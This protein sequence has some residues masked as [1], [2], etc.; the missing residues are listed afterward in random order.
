MW[1]QVKKPAAP[2]KKSNTSK[3]DWLSRLKSW[4]WTSEPSAQALKRQKK[5]VYQK[6]GISQRDPQAGEKLQ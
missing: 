5:R 1:G 4:V 3:A 2:E 6:A